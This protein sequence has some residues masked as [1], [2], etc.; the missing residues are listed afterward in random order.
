M[1]KID[2]LA[3][4]AATLTGSLKEHTL[5]IDITDAK[6]EIAPFVVAIDHGNFGEKPNVDVLEIDVFGADGKPSKLRPTASQ[7]DQAWEFFLQAKKN[8]TTP[9][10]A[11]APEYKENKNGTVPVEFIHS[12]NG[13]S[14][15][16]K[17]GFL[18]KEVTRLLNLK[19]PVIKVLNQ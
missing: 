13:Y 4:L 12:I 16:E 14:K 1:S 11:A 9:K 10:D 18:P 6:E 17:A 2:I 7:R 15:G 3:F 5:T 19:P 8:K